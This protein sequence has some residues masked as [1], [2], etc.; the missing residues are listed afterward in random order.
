[1]PHLIVEY[2]ANLESR[3]DLDGLLDRLHEEAIGSG[4]FPIGG[5]RIRAYK[6]L[7][8]RIADCD[9]ENAFV[10][11]TAIVGAGRPLDRREQVSRRLFEAVCD[12]LGPVSATSPLAISFNMREFDPVLSFK[13]N[14]LHEY[15]RKHREA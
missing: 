8:Y 7:D 1:M 14:N 3:F 4:M 9:R 11:V 12:V 2:S 15:V 10:H 5:I 13:K 6:A